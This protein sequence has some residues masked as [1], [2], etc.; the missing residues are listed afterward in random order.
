MLNDNQGNL[1]DVYLWII[2]K[3]LKY[4][5]YRCLK[6]SYIFINIHHVKLIND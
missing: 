3:K 6:I 1:N 2:I 4:N 5:T